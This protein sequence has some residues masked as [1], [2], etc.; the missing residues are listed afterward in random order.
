LA[1]ALAQRQAAVPSGEAGPMDHQRWV[2]GAA[3]R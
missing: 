2:E 1:L 3:F